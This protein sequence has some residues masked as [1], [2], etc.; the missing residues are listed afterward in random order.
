M[1]KLT[2][3]GIQTQYHLTLQQEVGL[4]WV[5]SISNYYESDQAIEEY[6]WLGMS[7]MMREWV[8]GRQSASL[9]EKSLKIRNVHYEATIPFLLRDIN[10]DKSGVCM[11]RVKDLAQRTNEHWPE[12]LSSLILAGS[13]SLCY[14]GQYFFDTDHE[15]GK[16][17]VQSNSISVDISEYPAATHG[18]TTLPAVAELQWAIAAGIQKIAGI[19]DDQGQP[20]NT[21]ARSFMVMVPYLWMQAAMQAAFTPAQVSETQTALQALK[22]KF[23]L[24]VVANPRL[25]WTTQMAI[26]R[27]DSN[28]KPFI[29]QEE[30][31]PQTKMKGAGSEYEFDNDAWEFGVDAWRNA[32]Y[33]R[34]QDSCLITLT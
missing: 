23:S 13:S 31:K 25:T 16:S 10:R 12:L 34:W 9:P 1:I 8:G 26:F 6:A 33:G 19:K 11:Q 28:I 24:D 27:T 18:S 3:R 7:P 4:D 5:P 29:R 21:G 17:G 14:D 15:E 22:S 20:M 32:G 30:I 2:E